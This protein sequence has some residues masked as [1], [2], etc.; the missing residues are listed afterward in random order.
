M[1]GIFG[2]YNSPGASLQTFYGLHALQHRGQEAAG[3]V[4]SDFDAEKDRRVF[5]IHKGLGLVNEV[6][7][8]EEI[9]QKLS[10]AS[11]IG[12]NRYSTTGSGTSLQNIQPF[13]VN[14]KS[15]NL[16]LTHNGN[17]SNQRT[18]RQ[19]LRDDG[20]I[21]QATSDTELILHLIARSKAESQLEQIRD[22][23]TQI[24]G[25]F[26]LVILTDTHLIA[27]R[28]PQ[29]FRPL[30]LGIKKPPGKKIGKT[31]GKLSKPL[32][33]AETPEYIVASETCAFD[34]I[35][36]KYLREVEP[37]E[38]VFIDRNTIE[39]GHITSSFLPKAPRKARCIFEFV[40]FSRPDSTVFGESVDKVRRKIGKGLSHESK[41]KPDAT[42]SY[43][44]VISV[45]DSSNTAALGFVT[46]SNKFG[47]PARLELGL[48]RNH[49][50]GRTF[51]QPGDHA[52]EIKVRSKYNTVRGVLKG[53]RIV[54]VDDSIV[55]GT[56]SKLLVKLLHEAA[57]KEIHLCISSPPI[58]NP[59][60]Y[61]MDF[62]TKD[63]L[64][65]HQFGGN[66][67][68]IKDF[69]GVESLQYLSLKGLLQSVPHH[70][71]ETESDE[72]GYCTACFSGHYPV[73]VDNATTVKEEND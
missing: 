26:S 65:A 13:A 6:F 23:L 60:F 29:G 71:G 40:Y 51:I 22:A 56:T 3:I 61:G 17:L 34:I 25:A 28:D 45:P 24:Q 2:I 54:V 70:A 39:T 37:G 5:R 44:T 62:P 9:F 7:R 10:G 38:I 48:I 12:Q 18:I 50:V 4:T 11:A 53:R 32:V 69:L 52:R 68:K 63:K 19:K 49:Y 64:I 20:V 72:Y 1:C 21:F 36:A 46:E 14:Y 43:L 59:C 42:E 58:M 66:I 33:P 30:S 15:G 27:A 41:L 31:T 67:E 57:P 55:R 8:N 73:P 47:T 35:S 16:A